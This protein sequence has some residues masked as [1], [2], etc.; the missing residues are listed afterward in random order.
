MFDSDKTIRFEIVTPE[1]TV[2][3]EEII[4]VTIPTLEGE[5]TILPKHMPL[6]GIIKPG[7]L[8]IKTADNRQKVVYVAGGFLEV[9]RNKVVILADSAERADEIDFEKAEEARKKAE[10]AMKETRIEDTERFTNISAALAR[11]LA[12]TKAVQRWKNIKRS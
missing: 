2:L 3:K 12:K 1:R 7:V 9:L 4:Q 11:E 10:Q 8:E 6:V 5:V